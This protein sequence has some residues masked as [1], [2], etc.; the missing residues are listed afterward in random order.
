MLLGEECS[1]LRRMRVLKTRNGIGCLLFLVVLLSAVPPVLWAQQSRTEKNVVWQMGEIDQTSPEFG[2]D[3]DW[4]SENL[5]P[6]F[7]VGQSKTVDWPAW[8]TTSVNGA[9]APPPRPSEITSCRIPVSVCL[10][11]VN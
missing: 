5:K 1:Q 11:S 2:Q 9:G 10:L 6:V 8:Q 7:T 3:F 4:E